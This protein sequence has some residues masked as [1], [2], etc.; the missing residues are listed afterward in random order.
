MRKLQHN[1]KHTSTHATNIYSGVTR[2]DGLQPSL[3]NVRQ[4]IP[5]NG[6]TSLKFGFSYEN[7]Q[8][9]HFRFFWHHFGSM[10]LRN[11]T[12]PMSRSFPT[13]SLMRWCFQHTCQ[14]IWRFRGC[15]RHNPNGKKLSSWLQKNWYI[16]LLQSV[17]V[18]FDDEYLKKKGR[19]Y[20][21]DCFLLAWFSWILNFI[22]RFNNAFTSTLAILAAVTEPWWSVF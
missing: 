20:D 2:P 16:R 4:K 9:S 3:K 19:K 13:T 11:P 18:I 15:L 7:S 5:P 17:F 10:L 22:I 1:F 12:K 8:H 6:L 14:L 21:I